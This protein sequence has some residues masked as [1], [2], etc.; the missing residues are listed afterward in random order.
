MAPPSTTESGAIFNWRSRL[1]PKV[2]QLFRVTRRF[3]CILC[4]NFDAK[5]ASE[6]EKTF[7]RQDYAPHTLR[8]LL[9]VVVWTLQYCS[10]SYEL[11]VFTE[12]G[13]RFGQEG[14]FF[15]FWHH[16]YRPQKK[17]GRQKKALTIPN[18]WSTF[19][20]YR[21]MHGFA[22]AHLV[23]G[24]FLVKP[25]FFYYSQTWNWQVVLVMLLW[26]VLVLRVR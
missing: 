25:R 5:T 20:L 15:K 4:V 12:C 19:G 2:D 7:L 16:L 23:K 9:K 6:L 3:F 24:L 1:T 17:I 21:R 26:N 13:A 8:L 18:I 10:Y 22:P 14:I 11:P